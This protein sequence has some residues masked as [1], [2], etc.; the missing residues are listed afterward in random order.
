VPDT[1]PSFRRRLV[2]QLGKSIQFAG[3]LSHLDGA[4]IG[5][6]HAG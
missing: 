2:E 4:V 5:D 6:G 1:E 3:R